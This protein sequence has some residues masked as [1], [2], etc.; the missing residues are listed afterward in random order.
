MFVIFKIFVPDDCLIVGS[1]S[2]LYR[3]VVRFSFSLI[4]C[5]YDIVM[6]KERIELD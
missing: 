5:L 1:S 6:D 4:C 2:L 3:S